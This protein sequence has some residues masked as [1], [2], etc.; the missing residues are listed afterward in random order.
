MCTPFCSCEIRRYWSEYIRGFNVEFSFLLLQKGD[1]AA[2]RRLGQFVSFS[3]CTFFLLQPNTVANVHLVG[4]RVWRIYGALDPALL[5]LLLFSTTLRFGGGQVSG[6]RMMLLI[7]LTLFFLF[8]SSLHSPHPFLPPFI[9]WAVEITC[10][11][12]RA[13]HQSHDSLHIAN[14][15]AAALI[16]SRGCAHLCL[17]LDTVACEMTPERK[18]YFF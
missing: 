1:T 5:L 6:P 3:C 9:S 8:P 15:M 7:L 4:G 11:L 18:V 17:C 2:K 13:H 10:P 12:A 16:E 14:V